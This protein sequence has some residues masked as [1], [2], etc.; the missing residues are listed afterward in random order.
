MSGHGAMVMPP[1]IALFESGTPPPMNK[2]RWAK[3]LPLNNTTQK[4]V[5]LNT[6]LFN[7]STSQLGTCN[8]IYMETQYF[9]GTNYHIK[10]G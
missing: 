3:Y 4:H 10:F 8:S 6:P 1:K 5:I 7:Q 2:A 9:I